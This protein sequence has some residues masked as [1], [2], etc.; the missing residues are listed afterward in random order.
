M[1]L[2]RRNAICRALAGARTARLTGIIPALMALA[3]I[4]VPGLPAI[5]Q[6]RAPRDVAVKQVAGDVYFLFDFEG[7]NSVFLVTPD[8]VLV[9]DTRT[10]P[11]EG[12]DLLDRIRKVTDKPIKWVINSR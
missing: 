9:I 10:H 2:A 1:A 7:S 4:L 3:G 11:R 6:E 5:A 8:G 12:R